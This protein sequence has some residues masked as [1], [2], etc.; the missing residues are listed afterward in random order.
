MSGDQQRFVLFPDDRQPPPPDAPQIYAASPLT[1]LTA[2]ARQTVL[3]WCHIVENAV[4]EATRLAADPWLVRIH[5]PARLSAPWTNDGR[6]EEAVY[7]LNSMTL[8]TDTDAV[9]VVG[10]RGGSI[11]AGQELEWACDQGLPILYV[12]TKSDP[13]SRQLR[14]TP[15]DLTIR[16]FEH[17]DEL[18]D[19]VT[20]FVRRYRR[21]IED[22]P[23]RRASARLRAASSAAR[24]SRAWNGLGGQSKLE[25]A[26]LVR[27]QP[28]RIDLMLEDPLALLAAPLG[29]V[30]ALGAALGVALP[31]GSD[32][33]PELDFAQMRALLTAQLEYEWD[34]VLTQRLMLTARLELARGGV[35]RF[36][37]TTLDDWYRFHAQWRR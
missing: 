33:L 4:D 19:A 22:G 26:A 6:P 23:R 10:Y 34:D 9:I 15:A 20:S 25:V 11:G 14:G 17:P 1:G 30:L 28:V 37:L 16:A 8:W 35:R 29:R 2:E 31:F 24:L 32:G 18:R 7:R 13:I 27:L 21:T 5:V 3:A 36:P 12:T